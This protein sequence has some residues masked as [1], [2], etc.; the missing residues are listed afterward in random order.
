[1]N[2]TAVRNAIIFAGI[3]CVNA[4]FYWGF[5]DNYFFSDDFEWLARAVLAQNPADTLP[6]ILRI[7][8]RD[9]NP[10]FMILLTIITRIV[11]L[12]PLVFRLLSLLTFSAL[13]FA[14]FHVLERY[15]NV[16]HVIALS[17][18]LLLSVNVFV[19]E[20]VLNLSALVYSLSLLLF[21]LALKFF[22]EGK[23]FLYIVFILMAFLAKETVILAVIP[24]LFYEKEKKKR[25]FILASIGGIGLVRFLLQLTAAGTGTYTSFLTT[26]NFFYKFYF[27]AMRAMNISPYAMHPAVG[28]L[29]LLLLAAII[30]YFVFSRETAGEAGRAFLYF[31][32]FFVVFS[33]FFALLPKLSSR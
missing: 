23:R 2:S 24:L 1:M 30:V 9:F 25:L 11:G 4:F 12:S 8:G 15:F 32:L 6:E 5:Q 31:F 33:L 7:E 29:I 20:T 17:A 3:L 27:T 21:L 28:I 16:D 26:G 10:L 14:F 19:S 13:I 22:L 18:A